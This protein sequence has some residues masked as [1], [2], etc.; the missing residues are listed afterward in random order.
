MLINRP[1]VHI[2]AKEVTLASGE[3]AS[4][5]FAVVEING[6]Y[7]VKFLGIKPLEARATAPVLLLE[8]PRQNVWKEAPIVS[9]FEK[10]SPFF[11]LDF[12]TSQ[13]AR[14]PSRA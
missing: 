8:S 10:I 9:A 6:V 12:L 3:L 5:Y 7:D 2:V 14:A 1:Q 13:L 11:T 4:A